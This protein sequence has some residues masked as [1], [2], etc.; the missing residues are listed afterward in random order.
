MSW[1]YRG[2]CM[3]CGEFTKDCSCPPVEQTKRSSLAEALIN[4]TVGYVIALGGQLVV[5]PMFGVSLSITDNLL[6][7]CIFMLISTARS[8]VIRRVMEHL[9]IT[10]MM[11]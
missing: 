7:G 3:G 4:T 1:K 8:Y 6:I 5:F 2:I 11:P 9:R 10:G